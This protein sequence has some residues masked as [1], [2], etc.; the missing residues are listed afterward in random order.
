MSSILGIELSAREEFMVKVLVHREFLDCERIKSLHQ[1]VGDKKVFELCQHNKIGSI[2]ADALAR[3]YGWEKLASHW[4]QV[5]EDVNVQIGQYMVELE[6]A[7]TLLASH[8]IPLIA[9]KNSGITKILYPH[10]GACPMGDLDVLVRK[11]DFRR[12]HKILVDHGYTLKFRSPL[13]EENLDK[14]EQGGGAEYAVTLPNGD[15]LWFELQWRPV[16]GRWIRP[17]QEPGSDELVMRSVQT[18]GSNV[19]ILSPEDNLL[20]V[21]LHTA[22]HTFVRAPGFRLHTDIDRIVRTENI[23]WNLFE[24][25][26]CTLQVK[27]AVFFS[28]AFAHDFLGTP[29]PLELID[30]IRPVTW[31]QRLMVYWLK[32]VGLFN[33]DDKKWTRLGYIIFVALLY[34]DTKGLFK[35]IFPS[36]TSINDYYSNEKKLVIPFLYIRR[37]IGLIVQHTLVK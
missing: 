19:R 4:Q 11:T 24:T 12:A 25:R 30:R 22:K 9:L 18:K 17:D 33:P 2:A 34:D 31:K 14:A 16:A 35:S 6:K 13:E 28:L 15:K 20:Q 3:C 29:I 5:Y 32:Q 10:Y 23:N 1:F 27:T 7:A 8:D 21:A 37:I 26:I 36:V